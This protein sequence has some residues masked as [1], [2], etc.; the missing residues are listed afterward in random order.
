[1]KHTRTNLSA[2]P[3]RMAALL[4]GALL[5]A[6]LTGCAI[7]DKTPKPGA[8]GPA[9]G[10]NQPPGP[11]PSQLFAERSLHKPPALTATGDT[12]RA[13][14]AAFIDWASL[15]IPAE[16]E[17]AR[18][19]L[20]AA[21]GNDQIARAFFDAALAAEKTDHSRALVALSL[22]GEM[23]NRAA[24]PWLRD[25]VRRPLPRE[26]TLVNGEI[27][28]QT[29]LATLQAKAID[30]LAYLN[31]E[32]A[33]REVLNAVAQHPSRVVRAE[34]IDAYLWNHQDS[35]AARETLRRYVRKDEQIFL[36]R[37]RRE[38]GEPAESFNRKLEAYLKAHP[39]AAPPLPERQRERAGPPA[40][41]PPLR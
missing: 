32:S 10:T 22:L 33:N 2:L 39:D 38:S 16:R 35:Q 19:A 37:V 27:L 5:C 36:D 34:A 15:S 12:A 14:A 13:Q 11:L 6:H 1:M 41:E 29:A 30:G 8:D 9:P 21:S 40:P 25:F 23:R 20:A 18:R 17:D 7:G 31:S 4:G 26:G 24:E 3:L 28:E